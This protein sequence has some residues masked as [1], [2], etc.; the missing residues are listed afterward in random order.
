MSGFQGDNMS[1][2]SEI[3]YFI[4]GPQFPVI[5][6]IDGAFV[7]ARSGELLT[8]SLSKQ[9]ILT[10][11]SY[12]AIDATGESWTFEIKDGKA[13][14]LPAFFTKQRTK[15]NIIRWFNDRKNKAADE[16]EYPEKSLSSKKLARIVDEI[17][18]RII[19][20]AD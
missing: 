18:D 7:A 8:K 13:L 11:K 1:S 4:R 2:F 9:D 20:T 12:D 10:D 19:A 5:V 15:L 17:A 16:M 6:D 14:M 3:L